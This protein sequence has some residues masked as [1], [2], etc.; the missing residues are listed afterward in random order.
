[1]PVLI[2][3][4]SLGCTILTGM[5]SVRPPRR[6]PSGCEWI[7]VGLVNNMPDAALE[8]TEQQFLDLLAAAAGES[9]VRVRFLALR[10][11]PR[12]ERMQRRYCCKSRRKGSVK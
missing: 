8:S 1:M 2:D 7:E 9:W 3:R 10:G 4:A 11:A 5:E 6:H 12:S